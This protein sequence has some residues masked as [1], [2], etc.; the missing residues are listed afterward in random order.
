MTKGEILK[1][2]RAYCMGC[3]CGNYVE[4]ERCGI[5]K[6]ELYPFRFGKDPHPNEA[7]AEA[8][9]RRMATQRGEKEKTTG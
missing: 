5:P 7:K 1:A 2:I 4:V 9:R 8:M 6:C 3:S